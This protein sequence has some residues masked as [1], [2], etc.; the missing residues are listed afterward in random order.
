MFNTI[1]RNPQWHLKFPPDKPLRDAL[2][3]GTVGH[4]A[5]FN[6]HML[7]GI[8]EEVSK[9][10]QT[11]MDIMSGTG[12]I[13]L[14]AVLMRYVVAIEIERPFH[15][16]QLA[17]LEHL[18]GLD[19]TIGERVLLLH[20]DCREFLPIPVDHIIFSPPYASVLRRSQEQITEADRVLS[21][22]YAL[23]DYSQSRGNVGRYDKFL[24]N[25]F[26]E[27]IYGLCYKSLPLGGTMTVVLQDYTEDGRRMSLSSWLVKVC[28][29]LGFT[30]GFWEKREA[31]GTGYKKSWKAKGVAVV[32][33]EDILVFRRT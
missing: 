28:E 20:G 30:V 4:P 9:P 31:L 18:K 6:L 19:P 13:M 14:G 3:P 27:K 10:G 33:D 17:C 12:S 26:M 24:Y 23:T 7:Q 29:R 16:L 32:Q 5:K 8:I 11:I 15:E 22:G 25:Q 1:A 21:S 2:F